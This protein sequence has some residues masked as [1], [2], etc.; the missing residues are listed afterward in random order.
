MKT[1]FLLLICIC[2]LTGTLTAQNGYEGNL[3]KVKFD[4]AS[5]SPGDTI[6]NWEHI[7]WSNGYTWSEFTDHISTSKHNYLFKTITSFNPVMY[8]RTEVRILNENTKADRQISYTI[9]VDKPFHEYR[10]LLFTKVIN[11][12]KGK[13]VISNLYTNCF[14]TDNDSLIIPP[15]NNA[16]NFV[17]AVGKINSDYIAVFEKLDGG[18]RDYKLILTDLS[19]APYV[20]IDS[21]SKEI[22]FSDKILPVKVAQL[23]Q[24]LF[25]VHDGSRM[26]LYEFCN[27]KMIYHRKFM[28]LESYRW[29]YTDSTLY[30]FRN[31]NLE[32]YSFSSRDTSFSQQKILLSSSSL[33]IDNGFKYAAMIISDSLK[34]YSIDKKCIINSICIPAIGTSPKLVVDSPYVYIHQTTRQITGVEDNDNNNSLRFELGQNYPNPFNPSTTISYSIPKKSIVELKIY[35]MLGR[36]VSTLIN[37]MQNAGDYKV[38]FNGSSLPSGIYIYTIQAGEYRTSKK[39]TLLK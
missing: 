19:N 17:T 34:V 39:L 9:E 14:I 35:D 16:Y 11:A 32:K 12:N 20:M 6:G 5:I 22:I 37:K 33:A 26:N 25:L 36:E 18:T 13:W 38:Q 23:S 24:N 31:G 21:S 7:S 2:F 29:E 30:I 27:N 1:Y 3:L 10:T 8:D 4:A 15:H 28:D